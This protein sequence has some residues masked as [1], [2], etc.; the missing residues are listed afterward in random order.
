MAMASMA[1]DAA[2]MSDDMPCCPD[3]SAPMDCAD[4]PLMAICVSKT[5]QAQP[6]TGIAEIQPVTLA[7]CFRERP[8]SGKPRPFST[9]KTSS[10]AGPSGL[11]PDVSRRV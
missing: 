4:C 5:L 3:K 9:A 10:I 2:A 8:R 7:C 11:T 6:S 1:D